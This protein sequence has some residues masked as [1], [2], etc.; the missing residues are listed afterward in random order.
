M[1]VFQIDHLLSPGSPA[2]YVGRSFLGPYVDKTSPVD[3]DTVK[4]DTNNCWNSSSY[5]FRIEISGVYL[6]MINA[7]CPDLS[8][9]GIQITRNGVTQFYFKCTNYGESNNMSYAG[10]H[11]WYFHAG[12]I[13]STRPDRPAASDVGYDSTLQ[14]SLS[15]FLLY[16][17]GC[18][19]YPTWVAMRS[20]MWSMTGTNLPPV[21][22][23]TTIV[24]QSSVWHGDHVVCTRSGVYVVILT[25]RKDRWA[26]GMQVN[27][28]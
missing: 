7:I 18:P 25:T 10:F 20:T 2:F 28:S 16:A 17:P 24:N 22:F 6:I 11:A 8:N 27:I 14:T 15:G 21:E 26:D 5:S 1:V 3:F 9:V 13:I 12:D 4:L 19:S 23:D